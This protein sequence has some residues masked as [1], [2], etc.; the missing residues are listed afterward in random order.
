MMLRRNLSFIHKAS[1][2]GAKSLIGPFPSNLGRF[3]E[4][5]KHVNIE[6]MDEHEVECSFEVTESCANSYGTL[7]GG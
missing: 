6:R 2:H 3:D 4:V 1:K 7:H 5:L